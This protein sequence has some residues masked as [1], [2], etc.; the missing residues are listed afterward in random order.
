MYLSE[1]KGGGDQRLFGTFLKIHP[2]CEGMGNY[3][4][5]GDDDEDDDNDNDDDDDN[6][7]G[8]FGDKNLSS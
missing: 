3:C 2:F 6:A 5:D 8:A 7:T 1:Y 4:D